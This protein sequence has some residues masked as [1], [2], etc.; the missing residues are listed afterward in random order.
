MTTSPHRELDE[1]TDQLIAAGWLRQ[2]VDTPGP[3]IGIAVESLIH[4]GLGMEIYAESFDFGDGLAVTSLRPQT[5]PQA[6]FVK[7]AAG[8]TGLPLPMILAAADAATDTSSTPS[9]FE[10]LAAAG[11]TLADQT[12]KSVKNR[13]PTPI[14][15]HWTRPDG[16]RAV[17]WSKHGR[18]HL[19]RR[20]ERHL[21]DH[22]L[23]Y[24]WSAR[25]WTRRPP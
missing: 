25:T 11:W 18:S 14:F 6:P 7:W 3:D 16:Q 17:W 24:P 12:L 22:G 5:T 8:V 21:A 2:P 1:L 20:M 23:G 13:K 10:R 15:Q 9:T 4:R 19:P